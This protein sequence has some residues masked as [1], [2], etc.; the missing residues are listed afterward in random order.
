MIQS[1]GVDEILKKYTKKYLEYQK[2]YSSTLALLN[3]LQSPDEEVFF[4]YLNRK[5]IE[6]EHEGTVEEIVKDRRKLLPFL[7]AKFEGMDS[8]I[9]SE[10]ARL[11]GAV[12]VNA[13]YRNKFKAY[14]KKYQSY[15]ENFPSD[16]APENAFLK[17]LQQATSNGQKALELRMRAALDAVGSRAAGTYNPQRSDFPAASPG[18]LVWMAEKMISLNSINDA[19]AA[20]ERLLEVYGDSGRVFI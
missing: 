18:V 15:Q 7:N 2:L 16:L 1:I 5:G 11:K 3:Q 13:D 8:E 14:L 6:E 19:T 12:F 4:T 9:Y 10:V 20:M 17:L